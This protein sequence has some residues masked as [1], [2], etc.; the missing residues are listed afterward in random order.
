MDLLR[1]LVELPDVVHSAAARLE[2]HHHTY[3]AT[4]LAKSLQRFYEECRVVSAEPEELAISRAR[5]KLVEA[6]RI[7]FA[8][9]LGIMGMSAPDRM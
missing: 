7:V 3:Y 1:R 2:P 5:I 6:A 9:T 8:R 4:E